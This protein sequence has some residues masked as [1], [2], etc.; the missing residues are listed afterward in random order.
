VK[1]LSAKKVSV[2]LQLLHLLPRLRN[3]RMGT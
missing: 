1:E 2:L 3:R